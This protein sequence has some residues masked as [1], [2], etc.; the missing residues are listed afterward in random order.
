ML[1]LFFATFLTWLVERAV[2]DSSAIVESAAVFGA[3]LAGFGLVW[4][5]RFLILDR[6]LFKVT[7]HGAEPSA[8]ELSMMHSDLPI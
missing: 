8:D 6:W 7:H 3:Q 1:G 5:G 2:A 4:V